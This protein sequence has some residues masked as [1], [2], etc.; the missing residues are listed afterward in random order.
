MN[1]FVRTVLSQ[2]F[3]DRML[4]ECFLEQMKEIVKSCA[5]T[6]QTLLFSATMTDQVNQLATVSLN[7]P[8]KV[9]VD[10]N[11]VKKRIFFFLK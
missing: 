5:R 10:S 8:V 1:F 3:L 6:R 2:L 7:R 4:D 9:F 11:K